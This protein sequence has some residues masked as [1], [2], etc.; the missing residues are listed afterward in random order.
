MGR[1]YEE[2]E[3]IG[4]KKTKVVKALF[5]TG[6]SRGLI[7]PETVKEL[8]VVYT[9]WEP[10]IKTADNRFVRVKELELKAIRVFGYERPKPRL[11]EVSELPEEVIIGLDMMQE[12]GVVIEVR[13]ERAYLKKGRP[14]I[15]F[16]LG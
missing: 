6:A 2:V 9:G 4:F 13:E 11:Y 3:L 7:H 12:L 14:N 8:G 15:G 16:A 1:I 5:D 10:E